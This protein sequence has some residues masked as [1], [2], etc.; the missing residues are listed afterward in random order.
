MLTSLRRR[1]LACAAV[2]P[3]TLGGLLAATTAHAS[4]SPPHV[5]SQEMAGFQGGSLP[6]DPAPWHFRYVQARV[7]LPDVT[8]SADHAAFPGV[9]FAV[10]LANASGAAVLGISTATSGG[11]WN[12][13]FVYEAKP[14]GAAIGG[15][16]G[17]SSP[18]TPA[19]DTVQL[20]VYFDG[21]H[22]FAH[23]ADLTDHSKDWDVTCTDPVV[24]DSFTVAR[25]ATEFGFTPWD[26]A[27]VPNAVSG[28]LRLNG[29]T[30]I[31]ETNRTGIRG[32]ISSRWPQ[33]NVVLS[34][35]GA[36]SGAVRVS[37][38]FA[39][40]KYAASPDNVIRDGRNF[41]VWLPSNPSYPTP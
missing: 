1:L 35:N 10:H 20:S 36:S 24:S 27:H 21:N 32:S 9:G 17:H 26:T 5:F 11:P 8:G 31:V 6:G 3:V 12:A 34:T 14:T 23:V 38:P 25:V 19:G 30:N 37:T 40:G 15:C 16:T 41:S 22:L 13:A 4:V 39:W 7:T 2:I 33:R 28:N 18:A 29:F